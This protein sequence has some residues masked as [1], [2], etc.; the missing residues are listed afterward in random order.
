MSVV[1]TDSGRRIS[2]TDESGKVI[3]KLEEGGQPVELATEEAY[4]LT[5]ALVYHAG[6]SSQHN[7]VAEPA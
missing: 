1:I 5:T 2:V 6:K 7:N 4:Y 3:V